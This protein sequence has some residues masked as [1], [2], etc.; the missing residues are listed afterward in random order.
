MRKLAAVAVILLLAGLP[1]AFAGEATATG[2]A[3][4]KEM[5]TEIIS[6]DLEKELVTLKGP[7]GKKLTVPVRDEALASLKSKK[8]SAGDTV[9]ATCQD[10]G[11]G[12]CQAV[13]KL[14]KA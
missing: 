12:N 10:D 3:T 2:K 9:I 11:Q 1:L 14:A 7:D 6:M 8:V 13:T 4:T 5:T